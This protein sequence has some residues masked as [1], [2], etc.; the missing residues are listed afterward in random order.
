MGQSGYNGVF[1][2]AFF[3]AVMMGTASLSPHHLFSAEAQNVRLLG[4][5]DLQGRDSL[6]IVLKGNFAYIGHHRGEAFNP[7]TGKNEANGTS[8]VDVSDP[9]QPRV[10]A[11][12]PGRRGAESRA[13]QVAHKFFDGKDYLL[14][15]QESGDFIGFEAWD[16]TV[17]GKPRMVSTISHLQAAHKIWWD[18]KTGYAH[19]SGTQPGWR[20]QHLIIYDLRNPSQPKFVSTWGLPQQRPGGPG[21]EGVSLH[22]PVVDG[23]RAYLSYLFGGDMVILDI[24]D[25]SKPRM[26]SHLDFSPPFS[27]IHTTVP[28]K[29]MKAPDYT[30]GL[31]DARDFLVLSEESFAHNCRELRRQIYIVDATEEANPIPVAIFKVPDGDFC[32]RGGRFGPHQFAETKDGEIIGGTL[33]YV[34]YFNA[35]LR[36]VDIADPHHPREVGFYIPDPAGSGPGKKKTI[37]QTNDVDLDYRGLI[38]I[39]D[40]AGNGLHILEFTRKK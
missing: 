30:Q 7:L 37:I 15:N 32:E 8:I 17:K 21:G 24:S 2:K 5:H 28:F 14:R 23:N 16:I 22:H 10:V 4:H 20:G 40:R 18:V 25:P 35:G 31:G 11:H 26:I 33:L 34:A 1:F 36:V 6:Q 9:R 29:R 19:L 13:V 3:L 12:I 39:T 27:G 38:Y